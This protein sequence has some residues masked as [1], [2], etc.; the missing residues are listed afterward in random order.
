MINGYMAPVS[1]SM[2]PSYPFGKNREIDRAEPIAGLG[3]MMGERGNLGM[4]IGKSDLRLRPRLPS[5]RVAQVTPFLF[6][7]E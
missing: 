5:L 4:D 6:I 2:R 1:R 3:T 7:P